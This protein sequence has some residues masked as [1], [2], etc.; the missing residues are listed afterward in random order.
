MCSTVALQVYCGAPFNL[1]RSQWNGC[2]KAS[3]RVLRLQYCLAILIVFSANPCRKSHCNACMKVAICALAARFF[4]F[5]ADDFRSNFLLKTVSYSLFFFLDVEIRPWSCYLMRIS[6]EFC[7]AVS[8]DR[9]GMLQC[10]ALFV[11][12]LTEESFSFFAFKK[13]VHSTNLW[14]EKNI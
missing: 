2:A 3:R 9:S 5:N 14:H 6:F 4:S 8:A 1:C 10:F 13:T 11:P 12:Y 7:N